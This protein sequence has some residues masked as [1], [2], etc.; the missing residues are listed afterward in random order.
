MLVV[1]ALV[2]WSLVAFG[3]VYP[4]AALPAVV[5]CVLMALAYGTGIGRPADTRG[6][7][8]ALLVFLFAVALQIVPLPATLVEQVSPAALSFYRSYHL[9]WPTVADVLPRTLALSIEPSTTVYSLAVTA[10]TILLFWTCR[11]AFANGG[12][13]Q[14]IRSIA[15]IGL[16]VSLFAIVQ[17]ATSEGALIYWWWKPQQIGSDPL[18]PFVNRNHYTT[19]ILLAL[20]ACAGYVVARAQ[21]RENSER[22]FDQLAGLTDRIDTRLVWLLTAGGLMALTLFMSTSRSALIAVAAELVVG[23]ML[24]R[25]RLNRR[26]FWWFILFAVVIA[27]VIAM[28]ANLG[29]IAVRLDKTIS[30]GEVGRSVIWRETLPMA[31]DFRL[32]G[33]G[34]GTY[35]VA[36]L[37]YQRSFRQMAF[38]QAHNHYLQL[39]AEGGIL[40]SVPAVIVVVAFLR[41]ARRRLTQDLSTYYWIRAGA[42]TGLVGVAVQSIW[43]SGFR[44]P[45]NA[46]LGAVLA[47]VAVHL[48]HYQ[49]PP[50]APRN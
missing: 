31:R 46:L 17:R 30:E 39:F 50:G 27:F 18:G 48:V 28:W 35:E 4:W 7:D 43:E 16:A 11:Q 12:T 20:P 32:V 2:G 8:T 42:L 41:L 29:A 40:L 14:M 37:A 21:A 5:G 13:R 45:A 19:W 24:A 47:A 49:A 10:A 34:L 38:N 22:H 44:M 15:W 1:N 6:L 23:T 3:G 25:G 36:M 26:G 9:A 33:T